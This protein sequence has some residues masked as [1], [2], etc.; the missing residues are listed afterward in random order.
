MAN[1][2][3]ALWRISFFALGSLFYIAR[4]ALG[5][6]WRGEDTDRNLRLRRQ[7]FARISRFLGVRVETIG[8]VPE[9][10]GLLVCNHRSYF[11]PLI[12]MSRLLAY[13]V[14]KTEMQQW[15]VIGPGA[16]IS[17]VVFVDRKSAEGRRRA[18]QEILE[19]L[20]M[21]YF[22]INYPEGTTHTQAQTMAFKPGM[23]RD[24]VREGFRLYPV[25][26]EYQETKDAFVG[27]D[28]F[29]PHF[30]RCFGKPYTRIRISYGPALLS[31]DAE[32]L[33]RQCQQWIDAELLRLRAD[34]HQSEIEIQAV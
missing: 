17:G 25:A 11:D 4:I 5:N 14:G 31:E 30:F 24:A 3:R 10:S 15:P 6:W 12:I 9:Q 27:E 34:W 33:H 16:R 29:L 1:F 18:R 19:K 2:L 22:V 20:K 7:W 13:P 23:F 32:S 28:T 26:L 8:R 21:G